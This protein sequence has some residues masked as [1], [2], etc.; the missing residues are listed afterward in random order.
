[1]GK[2]KAVKIGSEWTIFRDDGDKLRQSVPVRYYKTKKG[3][4]RAIKRRFG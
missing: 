3:A 1:M 2:Y 4:E